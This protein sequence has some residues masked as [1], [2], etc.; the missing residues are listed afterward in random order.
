MTLPLHD[1]HVHAEIAC[2][3]S[4]VYFVVTHYVL[5]KHQVNILLIWIH[6]C[7]VKLP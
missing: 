1:M 2:M 3:Q 6:L 7:W 4:D 5:Y